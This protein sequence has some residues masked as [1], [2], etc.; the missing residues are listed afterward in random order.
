M[1]AIWNR[2]LVGPKLCIR[3]SNDT[4][5]TIRTWI[6]NTDRIIRSNPF[7]S[8]PISH[9]YTSFPAHLEHWGRERENK[10]QSIPL[11]SMEEYTCISSSSLQLTFTLDVCHLKLQQHLKRRVCS[12][13][14]TACVYVCGVDMWL[15]LITLKRYVCKCQVNLSHFIILFQH[16]TMNVSETR[17]II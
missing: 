9:S 1:N 12:V 3:L 7:I 16:I 6:C 14:Y 5:G 8:L 17:C 15:L 4:N 11:N 2:K 13:R 10:I